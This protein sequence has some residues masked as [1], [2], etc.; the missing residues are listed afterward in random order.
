MSRIDKAG[1]VN[2]WFSGPIDVRDIEARIERLE[3]T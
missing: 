2:Y 1:T 3:A